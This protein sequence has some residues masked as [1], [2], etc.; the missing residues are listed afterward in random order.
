VQVDIQ[1][2]FIGVILLL[3]VITDPTNL[4]AALAGVR[5]SLRSREKAQTPV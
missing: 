2:I 1:D 3:A 5:S 4:R